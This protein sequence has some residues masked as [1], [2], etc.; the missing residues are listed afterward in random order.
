MSEDHVQDIE[1]VS[2]YQS[3]GLVICTR[4]LAALAAGASKQGDVTSLATAALLTAVAASDAILSEF[5]YTTDLP[6]YT[7]KFLKAGVADKYK[8]ISNKK[9]ADDHPAVFELVRHRLAIAHSEPN[10]RRSRL[11]G[12]RISVDGAHWAAQT[13]ETFARAV[14]GSSMPIW[15]LN[16]LA[17]D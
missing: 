4:T 15:F 1:L 9:L 14:W 7:R 5:M 11:Y 12:N 2:V 8:C 16:T 3:A 17:G 10:N 13:V 6:G